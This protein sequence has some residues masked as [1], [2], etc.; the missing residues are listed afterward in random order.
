MDIMPKAVLVQGLIDKRLRQC[1]AAIAY[2]AVE[3]D[4]SCE[5]TPGEQTARLLL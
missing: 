5:K 1:Q 3:R 2:L 4:P